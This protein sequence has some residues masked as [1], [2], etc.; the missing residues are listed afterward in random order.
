MRDPKA[1]KRF[2]REVA[3]YET[4]ADLGLP[5][6]LDHNAETWED[7]RTAMYM[8]TELI[9]GVDL[10]TFVTRGGRADVD[11]ALTCVRELAYVLNRC[12]DNGVTHRD[13]KPAN[14]VL[15]DEDI[16]KPILVDFGLSFNDA[17]EDDITQLNEEVG[18]RFLRLP[19]H[20]SGGRF[21]ASDVTQLAGIFL[22]TITGHE[23][24]HLRDESD[25][26]PHRRPEARG[27]L[28]DLLEQRQLLRVLSV[29]DRAF[30][31]DLSMRYA[32]APDLINALESAM[33]SDQEGDSSLE[34]LLA[35]VDEIA[36]SRGLP[37]LALRRDSLSSFMNSLV[38]AA[39]DFRSRGLEWSRK[40]IGN[41]V[42][43]VDGQWQHANI[44][45]HAPGD[46]PIYSVY[47]VEVRGTDEYVLLIDGQ[48]MWR[49]TSAD[50]SWN[51][52]VQ[53]ALARQFLATQ[54]KS[55]DRNKA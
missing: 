10:G 50:S 18:N 54:A 8:A 5:R 4:L 26:M 51:A 35:Q 37:A 25:R 53:T 32:T 13:I 31:V 27:V 39:Q 11:A 7:R 55:A 52:A 33:R 38:R 19:E 43:S 46:D 24:R 30:A 16:T 17:E 9:Q 6:I 36:T 14:V 21:A 42:S 2:K 23:P 49:G 15:R 44:S 47:R 40:T 1:R 3:A 22:Y 41:E 28:E 20:S 12:H 48:E 34:D 45:V 29:L